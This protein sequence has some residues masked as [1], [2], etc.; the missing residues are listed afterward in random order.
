M[1][2]QKDTKQI[3]IVSMN[4]FFFAG[5]LTELNNLLECG[6]YKLQFVSLVV[7]LFLYQTKD[8]KLVQICFLCIYLTGKM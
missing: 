7:M 4:A 1:K 3:C 2:Y 6:S 5:E 8:Y